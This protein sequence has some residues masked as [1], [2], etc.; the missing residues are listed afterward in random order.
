MTIQQ[1][2]I[3]TSNFINISR[4]TALSGMI[5]RSRKSALHRAATS[6]DPVRVARLVLNGHEINSQDQ[7][8][9]T[10]LHWAAARGFGT[11]VEKLLENDKLNPNKQDKIGRTAL[12]WAASMGQDE[13]AK[14]LVGNPVAR[15]DIQDRTGQTPIHAAAERLQVGV[16]GVLLDRPDA[17]NILDRRG[18]SALNWVVQGYRGD[19]QESNTEEEVERDW[20][21]RTKAAGKMLLDRGADISLAHGVA[22]ESPLHRAART[23]AS[24]MIDLLGEPGD[25]AAA[26]SKLNFKNESGWTALHIAA[27]SGYSDVV[28]GLIAAGADPDLTNQDGETPL[29]LA[30]GRGHHRDIIWC[31]K[32]H[33]SKE[34][35]AMESEKK[36]ETALSMAAKSGYSTEMW[37]LLE[38][39]GAEIPNDAYHDAL[40][41]L[42]E[43][44][45][46]VKTDQRV[47]NAIYFLSRRR[48]FDD[49]TK[50]ID[51]KGV[52]RGWKLAFC[53]WH[54]EDV[55][56]PPDE[57]RLPPAL[58]Y[59]FE[60][61]C[62]SPGYIGG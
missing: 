10:P 25:E 24:W 12:H 1:Q 23:G 47:R 32:G 52:D 34:A 14:L 22:M 37:D 62:L 31:L 4:E 36:K 2:E 9:R 51:A 49:I 61:C 8:G 27:S 5:R 56:A 44:C 3:Q 15:V 20:E 55:F 48:G 7:D 60:S 19:M 13:A 29:H 21:K 40:E 43:Y 6:G 17:V 16:L 33:M 38:S 41:L 54:Q 46:E 18:R 50:R 57:S 45:K 26:A 35:F 30:V 53:E 28:S 58:T 39:R 42:I 11:V 59:Y